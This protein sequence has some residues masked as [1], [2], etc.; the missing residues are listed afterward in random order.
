M[1]NYTVIEADWRDYYTRKC[2][3]SKHN[4][5]YKILS[6]VFCVCVLKIISHNTLATVNNYDTLKRTRNLVYICIIYINIICVIIFN[7]IVFFLIFFKRW[8]GGWQHEAAMPYLRCGR[9]FFQT[10]KIKKLKKVKESY[11][12]LKKIK[13]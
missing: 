4:I 10:R 11:R 5:K 13:N 2:N 12:K 7:K 3:F 6:R 8:V 1:L 9:I